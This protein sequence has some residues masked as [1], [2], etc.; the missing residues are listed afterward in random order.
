MVVGK[1][2][3]TLLFL[4][5]TLFITAHQQ[6]KGQE[7]RAS[8]GSIPDTTVVVESA[9]PVRIKKS[10]VG[11]KGAD[12]PYIIGDK[13]YT[14]NSQDELVITDQYN[15]DSL[16]VVADNKYSDEFY[17]TLKSNHQVQKSVFAMPGKLVA[18]SDIEGNYNAFTGFLKANNII[19]NNHNWIF[20]DAHLVL[21]G[22]FVDRGKN[23]TQV[24]WLIYKMEQQAELAGGKVHFILGNHEVLNF[25]GDYRYNRVKY[26]EIALQ[27]SGEAD[28][29]KAVR[30]IY[31]N[32]SELGKWLR[33]KNVIEK[34]GGYLFVHAGLSTEL[35]EHDLR[36]G[37]INGTVRTYFD[38]DVYSEPLEDRVAQFLYGSKGPFWYRGLAVDHEKYRK[39][40]QDQ[41]ETILNFYD[42]RK[43]VIGHTLVPDI[44]SDYKRKVVFIDVSHGKKKNSV[45][46]KGLLIEN[47][48]EYK[49]D[50]LGNKSRL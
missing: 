24:L 1:K 31:S 10:I 47:G 20:E 40:G 33:T 27:I 2:T 35:L 49:I 18:I 22:D 19:D 41:L 4:I 45:K 39:V 29:R 17:V 15:L 34:I 13:M 8:E 26:V 25:Q 30:Y 7:I 9:T 43:I 6:I 44:I 11:L 38:Q 50:A 3:G 23:V 14:V 42:A 21:L 12:G 36:L 32:R 48:M 28:L 46:T 5:I 16:I 37:D